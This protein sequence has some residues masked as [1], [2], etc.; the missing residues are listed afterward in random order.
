MTLENNIKFLKEDFDFVIEKIKSDSYK[1]TML[2]MRRFIS[3]KKFINCIIDI[4]KLYISQSRSQRVYVNVFL[5][6]KNI[7]T[8][9][10]SHA[11]IKTVVQKTCT[12]KRILDRMKNVVVKKWLNVSI[13]VEESTTTICIM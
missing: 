7:V 4:K 2:K 13:N 3:G 6:D 1:K 10:I 12:K 11:L 9:K 5:T 8:I